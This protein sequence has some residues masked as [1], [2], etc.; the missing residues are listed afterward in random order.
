MA[1]TLD[2][3]VL[4]KNSFNKGKHS[5]QRSDLGWNSAKA[6]S[7]NIACMYLI[8]LFLHNIIVS[9]ATDNDLQRVIGS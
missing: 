2:I 1:V 3:H 5:F 9:M 6:Q 4:D 8:V 7:M